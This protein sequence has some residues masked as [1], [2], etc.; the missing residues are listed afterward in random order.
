[1]EEELQKLI[2]DVIKNC[3]HSVTTD[4][5]SYCVLKSVSAEVLSDKRIV[6]KKLL[7]SG[8][9][10]VDSKVLM[11]NDFYQMQSDDWKLKYRLLCRPEFVICISVVEDVSIDESDSQFVNVSTRQ[12]FVL[13][14]DPDSLPG[15]PH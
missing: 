8:I 11:D 14:K 2:E 3:S 7:T 6:E 15:N 10:A 4:W 13:F 5:L 12:I 1:M 9:P